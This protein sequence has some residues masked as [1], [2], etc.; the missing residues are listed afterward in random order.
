[1]ILVPLKDGLNDFVQLI[2]IMGQ[3]RKE[4]EKTLQTPVGRL[5]RIYPEL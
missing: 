2:S 4:I 3:M 1:M 5:G